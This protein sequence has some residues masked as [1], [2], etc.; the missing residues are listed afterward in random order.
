[1][2]AKLL[3]ILDPLKLLWKMSGPAVRRLDTGNAELPSRDQGG[4]SAK[5]LMV[6]IDR[7]R[8]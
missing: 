2:L 5:D 7:V 4:L 1:M 8:V 3:T 6:A